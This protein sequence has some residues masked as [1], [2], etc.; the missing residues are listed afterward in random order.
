MRVVMTRVCQGV[1]TLCGE[2]VARHRL[3][4][5][6][7]TVASVRRVCQCVKCTPFMSV[8]QVYAVCVTV[9]SVR[10]VCQCVKCVV[11]HLAINEHFD[12][13]HL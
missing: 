3:Y 10:R 11:N 13:L 5:V 2:H 9:S 1:K 7:F 6:C 8:C 12:S 4:A